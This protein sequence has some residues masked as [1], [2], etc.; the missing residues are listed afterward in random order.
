[1]AARSTWELTARQRQVL[2]LIADG[3][4]IKEIAAIL[5]ISTKTV[6]FHK[7]CLIRKTGLRSTAELTRYAIRKG[8]IEA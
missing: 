1:M 5:H 2:H 4:S 6:E 3:H 7:T 8:I